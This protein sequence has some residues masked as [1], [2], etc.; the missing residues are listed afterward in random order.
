[1]ALQQPNF[2]LVSAGLT[3]V[4]QELALCANMPSVREGQGF[5]DSINAL[6]MQMQQNHRE[7]QQNLQGMQQ[8]LQGMQDNIADLSR[9]LR[10]R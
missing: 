3:E 6:T 8:N 9:E 10:A 5:I 4:G 7:M 1:M 2:A